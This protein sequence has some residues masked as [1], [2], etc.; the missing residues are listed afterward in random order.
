M[1]FR[2][3]QKQRSWQTTTK[4]QILGTLKSGENTDFD[5]SNIEHVQ[6]LLEDLQA[7]YEQLVGIL[8]ADLVQHKCQQEE[9]LST[10]LVKL[11]KSI[12]QMTVKDFN[13]SHNCDILAILK[14]KD[15][16]TAASAVAATIIPKKREFGAVAATPSVRPRNVANGESVLRTVVK[17][18]GI[19]Y[20]PSSQNGSPLETFEKGSV[21]ATVSKKRR[22]NE[23]ANFEISVGEGKY[24]SLND[25]H[26]VK[27][28]DSD[29]KATAATQL[30]V[31]QDQMASLMAQL[32]N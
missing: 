16:V 19:Y 26:G 14:S 15:G 22:G 3:P 25:P 12:R 17:G 21:I 28:L 24:I 29:M 11:P 27:E 9:T 2:L 7:K 18:E 8:K 31:L 1:S 4:R 6:L 30:K 10:G 20:L 13:Q 32:Q 5:G 23:S